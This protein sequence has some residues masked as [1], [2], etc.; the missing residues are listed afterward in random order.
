[1]T[2]KVYITDNLELRPNAVKMFPNDVVNVLLSVIGKDPGKPNAKDEER[3]VLPVDGLTVIA[4]EVKSLDDSL[5]ANLAEPTEPA[6]E[7]SHTIEL[8]SSGEFTGG[9]KV[10]VTYDYTYT[11]PEGS[12]PPEYPVT[13]KTD[14]IDVTLLALPGGASWSRSEDGRTDIWTMNFSAYKPVPDSE[15]FAANF[16]GNAP[17][18]FA[19]EGKD[20]IVTLTKPADVEF[21]EGGVSLTVNLT[22]EGLNHELTVAVPKP[23]TTEPAAKEKLRSRPSRWTGSWLTSRTR[24]PA[25]K[26]SPRSRLFRQSRRSRPKI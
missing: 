23:E 17:E 9:A 21:P 4:D 14:Q 12:T 10:S 1:M 22:L 6:E 11:Y 15:S 7:P 26:W 16:A 2:I 18:G 13:G 3:P 25:W 5:E 20:W 19:V 24:S 8:R